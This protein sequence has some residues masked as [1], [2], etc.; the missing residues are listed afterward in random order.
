VIAYG[1]LGTKRLTIQSTATGESEEFIG[2]ESSD[3]T[4]LIKGVL[5][6]NVRQL[7]EFWF[8]KS[9]SCVVSPRGPACCE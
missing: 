4:A 7:G 1:T 5:I 2:M 3:G 9:V 6:R 8:L